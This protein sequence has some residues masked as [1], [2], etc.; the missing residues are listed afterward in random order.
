M[1]EKIV[2]SFETLPETWPVDG[3][4]GYGFANLLNGLFVDG[5]A[6]S[7][8]SRTYN[9]F[10][11]KVPE[12]SEVAY[13]ARRVVL[14]DLLSSE[15]T[16]LANQA[17]RIARADR[18]TRDY[19]LNLLRQA[20]TEVIACFPV[21]RTYIADSVSDVDRRYIDWAVASARRRSRSADATVFDFVRALLRCEAAEGAAAPVALAIGE[22]AA[23]VQQLTAPTMAKGVEDTAFYV[24]N[25]L[26]SLNDVGGNP[27]MFGVPVRSFHAANAD[28]ARLWP[29]AMLAS[30]THD[31][32][33]SED[34]RARIDVLSEMP[35]LWRLQLRRWSRANRS[36]KRE[37]DGEAAPSRNDEYLLYQTLLGT[38]PPGAPDAAEMAAYT[39]RIVQYMIKAT[40]EAKAETSWLNPN[41][42]YEQ[43]TADFVHALLAES[44]RNLFLRGFRV[45]LEPVARLGR[46][47]SLSMA[48]IKLTAP[49]VPDIYQGNELWDFSLVDPDNRRPVDFAQRRAM[50]TR[51]KALSAERGRLGVNLR[52][53][54]DEPHDGLAKA[55]LVWKA[56]DL[57][58]ARETLFSDGSYTPLAA[59]GERAGHVV[60]YARRHR[61][62]GALV[63][64]GRLFS[65]L[66]ANG[67]QSPC[68]MSAW[69]STTVRVPFLAEGVILRHA[70][71]GETLTLAGGCIV[72]AEVFADFCAAIL[73]YDEGE[74]NAE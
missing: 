16:V 9:A 8:M 25:R 39:E 40:R 58:R 17:A 52:R 56:L 32:K 72:V 12:F 59:E 45:V 31:N 41:L 60:A 21:Y 67:T 48:L 18:R 49:G 7:K 6:E 22:F 30:S 55:Y 43:A 15:L 2:A 19:T 42:P 50:L 28:A 64:A 71:T 36:K 4:T 13:R 51:A 35:A 74:I 24:Y 62:G 14:R 20:L 46:Y 37:V 44:K 57:R 70:F 65:A 63:I 33:R 3:T 5:A 26:A 68:G 27:E 73:L 34:V 53:A 61:G 1:I 29:H 10:A 54:L 66:T 47:N 69:G 11:G 23:K 38:C